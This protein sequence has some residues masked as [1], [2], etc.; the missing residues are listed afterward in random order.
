LSDSEFIDFYKGLCLR[1][2]NLEFLR[3]EAFADKILG[4]ATCLM[5]QPPVIFLL[6]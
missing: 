4:A 3:A 5:Q 1:K 2:G 6:Y